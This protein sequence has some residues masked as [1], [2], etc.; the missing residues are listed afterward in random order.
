MSV[1]KFSLPSLKNRDEKLFYNML[2]PM[3]VKCCKKAE[4]K[5]VGALFTMS[6]VA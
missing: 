3:R 2:G 1:L 4:I 6:I 5:V